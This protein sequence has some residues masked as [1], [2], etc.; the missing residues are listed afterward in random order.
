MLAGTVEEEKLNTPKPVQ[1]LL[2]EQEQ[3]D[4]QVAARVKSSEWSEEAMKKTLSDSQIGRMSVPMRN[5]RVDFKR[6]YVAQPTF[7]CEY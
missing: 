7:G 6:C 2:D 3:T 5:Q 1:D 4:Y